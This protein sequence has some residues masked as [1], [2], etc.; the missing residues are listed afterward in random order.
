MSV[1]KCLEFTLLATAFLGNASGKI[2][3]YSSGVTES[4]FQGLKNVSHGIHEAAQYLEARSTEGVQA[5]GNLEKTSQ[6]GIKDSEELLSNGSYVS[7][8][9]LLFIS[10][11]G[12]TLSKIGKIGFGTTEL[13]FQGLK[14]ASH[15]I[16]ETSE[17]VEG[18]ARGSK[19]FNANLEKGSQNL[20]D[21]AEELA[22]EWVEY[23]E[24]KVKD[25]Q[26]FLDEKIGEPTRYAY[27]TLKSFL[28]TETNSIVK[29]HLE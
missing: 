6:Q 14:N 21:N 3:K 12:D 10:S 19:E 15:G 18:F 17:W 29:L 7:G 26:G 24:E 1:T 20:A 4:A 16:K 11:A 23:A 28:P 22:K 9:S 5:S 2:G 8:Y 25:L 13:A 27:T